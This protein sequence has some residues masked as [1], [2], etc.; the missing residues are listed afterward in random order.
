L[1]PAHVM[2]LGM[3]EYRACWALQKALSTRR[4]AGEIPD[5]LL[6]VE[7]PPVLTLGPRFDP[8]HLLLSREEYLR[9]GIDVVETD[10]GGDVTYHGPD[11]LV[12]YPIFDVKELGADLHQWLRDL[13]EAVIRLVGKFGLDG[14]RF[15]PFTGVW[16]NGRKIAAIG[17]KVSRWVNLHGIALNC[18]NDLSPFH[19]IVPCGIK[20]YEVTSLSREVGREVTV[21]EAKGEAV[22]AFSEVF[23]MRFEEVSF[24]APGGMEHDRDI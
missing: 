12:M 6:L 16:V 20:G 19:L 15:P 8:R 2:D 18:N 1:R 9:R 13:E 7:H 24:P 3:M 17:V 23:S 22:R 10:R 21:E 11:Q 14:Y 5:T 4:R